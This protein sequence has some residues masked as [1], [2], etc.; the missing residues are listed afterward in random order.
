MGALVDFSVTNFKIK[1]TNLK[2]V[3]VAVR[4]LPRGAWVDENLDLEH[5]SLTNRYSG[6]SFYCHLNRHND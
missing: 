2:N 4:Q 1:K 6:W 3:L 5:A